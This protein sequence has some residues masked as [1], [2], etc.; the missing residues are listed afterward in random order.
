MTHRCDALLCSP[1]NSVLP[2]EG[3]CDGVLLK[4][5]TRGGK[6][7]GKFVQSCPNLP[8]KRIILLRNP[9]DAIWASYQLRQTGSHVGRIREADFNSAHFE[10]V[11]IWLAG[12]WVYGAHE[13]T[14]FL[15]NSPDEHALVVKF[16]GGFPFLPPFSAR[17]LRQAARHTHTR[18]CTLWSMLW[19]QISLIARRK[20]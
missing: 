5:H 3:A 6:Y 18:C 11:A 8:A 20:S 4:R 12:R 2:G 10:Q 16:E 13:Y 17:C 1:P 15:D 7:D 14:E 9:F 19:P